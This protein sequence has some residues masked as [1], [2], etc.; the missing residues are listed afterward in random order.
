VHKVCFICIRAGFAVWRI[1]LELFTAMIKN[2]CI[3]ER[4]AARSQRDRKGMEVSSGARP[5]PTFPD[6]TLAMLFGHSLSFS[7]YERESAVP[8]IKI[9]TWLCFHRLRG[10][11]DFSTA[12]SR[13]S[14]KSFWSVSARKF[15]STLMREQRTSK[16]L[17]HFFE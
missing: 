12:F 17:V 16:T 4:V 9:C 13:D 15:Q 5:W 11:S 8:A 7:L 2:K 3:Y 6:N 1:A 10:F 14:L